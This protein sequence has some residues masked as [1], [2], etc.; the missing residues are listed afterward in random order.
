VKVALFETATTRP[1]SW[2]PRTQL[3]SST[4]EPISRI[5]VRSGVMSMTSPRTPPTSTRSPTR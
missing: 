2:R 3:A 1:V 4:A 5:L